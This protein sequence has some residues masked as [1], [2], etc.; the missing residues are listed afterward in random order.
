MTSCKPV[1]TPAFFY[2]ETLEVSGP[3]DA[4]RYQEIVG[5]LMFLERRTR[6][7]IS[8]AVNLISRHN[9]SPTASNMIAAKR[10]LRYLKGTTVFALRLEKSGEELQAFPNADWAGNRKDRKSTSGVL[11]QIRETSVV[12]KS[13]KQSCTALSSAESKHI[14]LR[15]ACKEVIL[16][17]AILTKLTESEVFPRP[18]PTK[19][20]RR[21]PDHHCMGNLR[22][23]QYQACGC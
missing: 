19:H 6:P 15:E 8:V 5:S 1:S 4:S 16:M 2:I 23:S 11:L 21:Q 14:C 10:V 3:S 12:W 22:G 7:D 9:T 17:R 20:L 13:R 18:P